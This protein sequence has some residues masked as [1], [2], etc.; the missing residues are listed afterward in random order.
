MNIAPYIPLAGCVLNLLFAFFVFSRSPKAAANRIYLLIGLCIAMWNL[1]SYR[2]FIID[3]SPNNQ[4]E[5]LIWARFIHAGVI[6]GS[7]AYFHLTCLMAGYAVHRWIRWLYVF[8]FGVLV[9]DSTDLIIRDVRWMGTSG[10]YAM[11]GP[12][13]FLISLALSFMFGS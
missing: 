2:L 3:S 10:W 6:L 1:G 11:A 13:Y 4:S 7:L 12:C 5:A 9:L 8:A